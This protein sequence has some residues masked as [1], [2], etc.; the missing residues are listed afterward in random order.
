MVQAMGVWFK[1]NDV[2][3]S[4]LDLQV[5]QGVVPV[6]DVLLVEIL[7]GNS[8]DGSLCIVAVRPG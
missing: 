6:A 4:L 2:T 1:D 7:F 5:I 8:F 3:E